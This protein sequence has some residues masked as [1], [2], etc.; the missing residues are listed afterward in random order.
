MEYKK[1]NINDLKK[2]ENNSRIHSDE[3]ILQIKE[4]IK[5]FGFT[6]PLLV[7]PDL[8][9]IAGHGRLEAIKALNKLEYKD[10]PISEIPC[11]IVSGL[12]EN[13]YKALVIADNKIALN[14]G[15]DLDILKEELTLLENENYNLDLLGFNNDELNGLLNISV[16]DVENNNLNIS[17]QGQ[18]VN[19]KFKLLIELDNE[20]AL[21]ILY[22]NLS[23]K[24]YK[25]K[26]LSL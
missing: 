9:I 5:Q 10:N 7:K 8:T 1:I 2:Y 26:V 22:N 4:S 13:D 3:Q 25:C 16:D 21:E 19:E 14:A 24:G 18:E 6:N 11:I 20:E 15:W 17:N 12:S 23:N